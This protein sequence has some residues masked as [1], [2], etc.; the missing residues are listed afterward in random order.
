MSE[1]NLILHIEDNAE[2]R[3]IVHDAFVKSGFDFHSVES[4]YKAEKFIHENKDKILLVITDCDL[5]MGFIDLSPQ[6]HNQ[7][8][9]L[10]II[11]IAR[12]VLPK[13]TPVIMFSGF[14]SAKIMKINGEE[15][16]LGEI[17]RSPKFNADFVQK[18]K[19]VNEL[20]KAV[21]VVLSGEHYVWNLRI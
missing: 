15:D 16:Y 5:S 13:N 3:E 12:S 17:L 4:A 9:G 6:Q 7:P 8:N 10:D 19:G 2:I 18:S 20:V 1:R 21:E 14:S 11:L